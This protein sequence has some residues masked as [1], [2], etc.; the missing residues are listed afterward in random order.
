MSGTSETKNKIL[1]MLQE[2]DMR[3][4]DIYPRLKLTSTTTIQHLRELERMGLVRKI[5]DQHFRNIKY[6]TLNRDGG[7]G[8][9]IGMGYGKDRK[10]H[11][12]LTIPFAILLICG[13]LL[14]YFLTLEGN[15][16]TANTNGTVEL[17]LADPPNVP[18]GTQD[19]S[20]TYGP[21]YAY[22]NSSGNISRAEIGNGGTINLMSVTNNSRMIANTELASG[23]CIGAITFNITSAAIEVNGITYPVELPNRTL[24]FHIDNE[25][26]MQNRTMA[27]LLEVSPTV[28]YVK[29][30]SGTA[31]SMEESTRAMAMHNMT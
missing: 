16:H 27:L 2:E 21:I 12:S 30:K 23:L 24:M 6:Y 15:A 4:I 29:G 25:L 20:I 22:L 1:K 3:L 5:P 10:I 13:A 14:L 8:N 11:R 31:F 9:G 26:I 28:T 17:F 19:L 18:N 7:S